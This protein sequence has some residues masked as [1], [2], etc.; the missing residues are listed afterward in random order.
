MLGA[1]VLLATARQ[2][3][4]G[5]RATGPRKIPQPANPGSRYRGYRRPRLCPRGVNGEEA[6]VIPGE[7]V[8]LPVKSSFQQRDS[9]GKSQS[10]REHHP[11]GRAHHKV[12]RGETENEVYLHD[13]ILFFNPSDSIDTVRVKLLSS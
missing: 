5:R 10:S 11:R 4:S 1:L 8:C 12:E 7:R 13:K 3:R 6:A 9:T 2:R